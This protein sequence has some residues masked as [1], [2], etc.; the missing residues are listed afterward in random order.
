MDTDF[1]LGLVGFAALEGIIIGIILG[2][3]W[4][5]AAKALQLF[6]LVEFIL[7]KWLESRNIITVDW[8]RLTL[9]L[10]NEG[11]SSV[12]EAISILESLLD[13]GVF[14]INVAIGFLIV[15]KFKS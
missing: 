8:N 7:F 2:I 4:S 11:E 13:T 1:I 12:N 15:R 10:L 5:M 9:G 14:T 6:L 3:I